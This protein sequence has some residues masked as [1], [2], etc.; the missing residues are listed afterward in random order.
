MRSFPHIINK[1]PHRWVT[2][3][4]MADHFVFIL[5]CAPFFFPS[6]FG[7]VMIR[8]VAKSRGLASVADLA[9][10]RGREADALRAVDELDLSDNR[11]DSLLF[12]FRVTSLDSTTAASNGT[13][14]NNAGSSGAGSSMH[15]D[16]HESQASALS[17]FH[18]LQRLQLKSNRL[19]RT[20]LLG[21]GAI[22][23]TLCLLDVSCNSLESLRGLS[24]CTALTSLNVSHNHLA[25]LDDLPQISSSSTASLTI[26]ANNNR[27]TSVPR[28]DSDL[29]PVMEA[30]T[31]L[32]I[33]QNLLESPPLKLIG[34]MTHSPANVDGFNA[35]PKADDNCY[36]PLT[37]VDVSLNPFLINGRL[38]FVVEAVVQAFV[39]RESSDDDAP[40]NEVLRMSARMSCIEWCRAIN[41]MTLSPDVAAQEER[42]VKRKRVIVALGRRDEDEA[43]WR[44][45]L[46]RKLA[47][48]RKASARK[49]LVA[50][51]GSHVD[52]DSALTNSEVQ[53]S[54]EARV[55]TY[56]HKHN[57]RGSAATTAKAA[58]QLFL[59]SSMASST[60]ATAN[61]LESSRRSSPK[62]HQERDASHRSGATNSVT[63][64]HSYASNRSTGV[65]AVLEHTLM[66]DQSVAQQ[67]NEY[68]RKENKKQLRQLQ[69]GQRMQREQLQTIRELQSD[70]GKD[71]DIIQDLQDRLKRKSVELTCMTKRAH[72]AEA[73]VVAMQASRD[74][75][76]SNIA[77]HA[78]DDTQQQLRMMRN[79]RHNEPENLTMSA[80]GELSHIMEK[81]VF[82]LNTDER[83]R[84]IESR[85]LSKHMS[86]S[87]DGTGKLLP[88][89][90]PH[91]HRSYVYQQDLAVPPQE[92]IRLQNI[93]SKHNIEH[94]KHRKPQ[95]SSFVISG[96]GAAFVHR[97]GDG[98]GHHEDP[99]RGSE[100]NDDEVFLLSLMERVH[101]LEAMYDAQTEYCDDLSVE[102]DELIKKLEA[103][104][105][106]Q[107][108]AVSPT[109]K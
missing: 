20:S 88:G 85:A 86:L 16:D 61:S 53:V 19:G 29:M 43:T 49:Q 84:L 67:T 4:V 70:H 106:S 41:A 3:L 30:L 73:R 92:K 108:R 63:S 17:A 107:V 27:I 21:V 25:R 45:S 2:S 77:S 81:R 55:S 9:K 95:S 15:H 8:V 94:T 89:R 96:D 11:I 22:A 1:K 35:L 46:P 48:G 87:Y 91:A 39:S 69:D 56:R 44:A 75:S 83:A 36:S 50:G 34:L 13:S 42:I 100:A 57:D 58:L 5:S 38:D 103:L 66:V 93:S 6:H 109:T 60:T 47:Q 72:D 12:E 32:N 98:G 33:S 23:S 105:G 52:D 97:R 59:A 78:H 26:V 76:S 37:D 90:Y 104:I 54:G 80:G 79:S 28:L 18:S 64:H 40:D 24:A 102:N 71:L 101:Q 51:A 99:S 82:H 65:D 74:V 10:A 31:S 7:Q 62:M 68:L 14:N